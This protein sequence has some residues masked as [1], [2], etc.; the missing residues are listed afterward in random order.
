MEAV[1]FLDLDPP[2]LLVSSFSV[3]SFFREYGSSSFSSHSIG[4]GHA[5]YMWPIR[6]HEKQ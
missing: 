4:D 5:R 3:N 1:L 6:P 2:D